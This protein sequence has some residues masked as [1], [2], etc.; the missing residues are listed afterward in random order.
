MT[1][2]IRFMYHKAEKGDALQLLLC[3]SSHIYT[4]RVTKYI[5]K[6]K[7][8]QTNMLLRCKWQR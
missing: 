2:S 3:L 8:W 5:L 1:S 7:V 6:L 4:F